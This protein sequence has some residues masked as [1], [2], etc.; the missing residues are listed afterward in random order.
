MS[1]AIALTF[2]MK[3]THEKVP[4]NLCLPF[5]DPTNSILLIKV[6]AWC[7][8]VLQVIVSVL[9]LASHS[10]LV[11]KFKTIPHGSGLK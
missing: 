7:V 6:I 10:F 3:F 1:I 5:V 2:L 4:L 8:A 11:Q 9:I